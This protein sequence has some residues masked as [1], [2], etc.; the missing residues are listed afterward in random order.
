MAGGP[1][2]KRVMSN[3][4]PVRTLRLAFVCTK[5]L[6]GFRRVHFPLSAT[7]AEVHAKA[8]ELFHVDA[9]ITRLVS[10]YSQIV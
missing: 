1:A 7:M 6:S 5:N 2:L 4:A 10:Q 3:G 8:C 9:A